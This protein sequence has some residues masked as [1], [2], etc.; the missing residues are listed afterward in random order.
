MHR[1][2]LDSGSELLRVEVYPRSVLPSPGR[3]PGNHTHLNPRDVS[4]PHDI[5]GRTDL[6]GPLSVS[7]SRRMPCCLGQSPQRVRLV[8][9]P[10]GCSGAL[11]IVQP[12]PPVDQ[13]ELV[14]SGG[15]EK[16]E[17]GQLDIWI[18]FLQCL[19]AAVAVCG[20]TET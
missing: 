12:F 14:E 1:K 17:R 16:V 10:A 5:L 4:T 20:R 15:N 18:N 8:P 9:A 6:G 11:G 7:E 2:L 19:G 3:F 13:A